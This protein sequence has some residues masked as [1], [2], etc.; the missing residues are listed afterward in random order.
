MIY[1]NY[2]NI[3][4]TFWSEINDSDHDVIMAIKTQVGEWINM[5]WNSTASYKSMYMSVQL[6]QWQLQPGTHCWDA[7]QELFLRRCC[8]LQSSKEQ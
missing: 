3:I 4:I 8:N 5:H 7:L 6:W 2:N 1:L